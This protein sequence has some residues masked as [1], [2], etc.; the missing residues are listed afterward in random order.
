M[1]IFKKETWLHVECMLQAVKE[2]EEE[3]RSEHFGFELESSGGTKT[4]M[5]LQVRFRWWLRPAVIFLVLTSDDGNVTE[6]QIENLLTS[7]VMMESVPQ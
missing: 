2:A 5:R 1:N 7:A 4:E 6:D 3:I